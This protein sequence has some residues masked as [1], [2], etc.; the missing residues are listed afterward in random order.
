MSR[1][2]LGGEG[3]W[4]NPVKGLAC[5]SSHTAGHMSPPHLSI[6][7]TNV[8]KVPTECPD[9]CLPGTHNLEGD[10]WKQPWGLGL[11]ARSLA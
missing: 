8:Y 3:Q 4:E 9:L 1:M 2:S 7:L 5:P 10:T 6:N 11:A